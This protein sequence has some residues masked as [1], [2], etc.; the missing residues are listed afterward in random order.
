M[1][2]RRGQVRSREFI[3]ELKTAAEEEEK[4]I[5]VTTTTTTTQ[6]TPQPKVIPKQPKWRY[7][8]WGRNQAQEVPLNYDVTEP[9]LE[10]PK[11]Q[12]GHQI[13]ASKIMGLNTQT[14]DKGEGWG[15][16]NATRFAGALALS[17][18]ALSTLVGLILWQRLEKSKNEEMV[19]FPLR[20]IERDVIR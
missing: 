16:Q 12:V 18:A 8:P 14:L 11:E 20:R 6:T 1:R 15:V 10:V 7:V 13:N 19:Q 2:Q 3:V 5:T 9:H 17:L 4:T